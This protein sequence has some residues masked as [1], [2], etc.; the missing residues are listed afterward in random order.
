[1]TTLRELHDEL[2]VK[3]T[4]KIYVNNTNKKYGT[5]FTADE[6]LDAMDALLIRLNTLGKHRKHSQQVDIL[7]NLYNEA[8]YQ[9]NRNIGLKAR[10]ERAEKRGDQAEKIIEKDNIKDAYIKELKEYSFFVNKG[11]K[12]Q[13]SEEF[14]KSI[15]IEYANFLTADGIEKIFQDRIKWFEEK[16]K[17]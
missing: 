7:T 17:Y 9:K 1:M 6:E 8:H 2:T 3:Q 5:N 16:L 4:V 14:L 13:R 15:G 11:M 10:A 12:N